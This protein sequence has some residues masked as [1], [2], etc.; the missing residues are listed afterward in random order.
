MTDQSEK[1]IEMKRGEKRPRN[2]ARLQYFEFYQR[3]ISQH[4][5]CAILRS[6]ISVFVLIIKLRRTKHGSHIQIEGLN[7]YH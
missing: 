1:I 6:Q 3:L 2:F 5:R 4:S 7:C